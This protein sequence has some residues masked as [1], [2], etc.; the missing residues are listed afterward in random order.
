[1][2]VFYRYCQ[3]NDN[4]TVTAEII[5]QADDRW[6]KKWRLMMM[7]YANGWMNGSMG[8]GMWIWSLVGALTVVLLLVLIN[9]QSKK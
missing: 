9:N 6:F 5:W 3:L 7:D 1:M 2:T 8:G 4:K